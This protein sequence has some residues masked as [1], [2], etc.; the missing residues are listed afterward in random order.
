MAVVIAYQNIEVFGMINKATE[1]IQLSRDANSQ[2]TGNALSTTYGDG[3]EVRGNYHDFPSDKETL[4]GEGCS[5]FLP[6]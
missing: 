3:V 5:F 6:K 2:T 4:E 1:I